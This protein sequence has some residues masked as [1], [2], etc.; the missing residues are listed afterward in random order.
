MNTANRIPI[1]VRAPSTN[2]H[3]HILLG[4]SFMLF[5]SRLPNHLV[6]IL[7]IAACLA[8]AVFLGA[9]C[10][11]SGDGS[12]PSV[13]L[14]EV[15]GFGSNPGHLQM[16]K[17]VPRGIR[18][19]APLVV[20]I[21]G[22]AQSAQ[23]FADHSGWPQ[24]ADRL[25][26]RMVFPQQRITNNPARCFNWFLSA[27][28]RRDSGEALSIKQMIDRMKA[29][30]RVD[31]RRVFVTGLSA[32]GAMTSIMLATYPDVFAAGAIMAGTP[33]GCAEKLTD[34]LTCLKP[35]IVP[36]PNSGGI[37]C[38]MPQMVPARGHLCRF[39]KERQTTSWRRLMPARK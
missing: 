26:L 38:E 6:R 4:E 25:G 19:T 36:P 39:G 16:F 10:K 29:D 34:S 27:N 5:R 17:Y 2:P 31:A 18:S 37:L 20:A 15:A 33:Y 8:L 35:G 28:S 13:S 22:C 32:G 1:K 12:A 30:Y 21:H 9:G 3:T 14:V 24:I 11:R 7:G 23:D